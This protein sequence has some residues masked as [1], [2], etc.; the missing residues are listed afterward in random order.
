M[1]K[2]IPSDYPDGDCDSDISADGQSCSCDKHESQS[3]TDIPELFEAQR[4]DNLK[5]GFPILMGNGVHPRMSWLDEVKAEELPE[6]A[7]AILLA[8]AARMAIR[9]VARLEGGWNGSDTMVSSMLAGITPAPAEPCLME[10]M[11][12][13]D[14]AAAFYLEMRERL[15]RIGHLESINARAKIAPAQRVRLPRARRKKSS[16]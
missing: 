15:A 16:A 5:L 2:L 13:R 4:Q 14:R 8:H 11:N 1:L 6:A 12:E 9:A 10:I 3:S 7:D